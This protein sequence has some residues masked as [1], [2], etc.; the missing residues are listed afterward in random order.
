[1]LR[2]ARFDLAKARER[3]HL[4]VG[5][6][7]AV[8]DIDAVIA[9]IRAS[10]DTATAR[11]ALMQR[12]WPAGDVLSLLALIDDDANAVIDDTVR[13]TEAQAN[14]ILQLRLQRL[15]GL[16]REKIQQEVSEVAARISQL[17]DL[18]ASHPRRMEVMRAEL[19]AVRAEIATPRFTQIVDG[20]ADQDDESLIEPGQ[21]VVT[22]TREGFIKRT[23][24]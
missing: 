20:I 2:R 19:A 4:L 22:I 14:G 16:E 5:L 6:A 7:I 1:I 9:L 3:A 8:A 15:T 21:M 17:L 13:L 18:I 24:L 12:G 23:P 10:A 11:A